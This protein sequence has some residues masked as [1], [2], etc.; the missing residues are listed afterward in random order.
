MPVI[1]TLR[2]ALL[3]KQNGVQ[4]RGEDEFSTNIAFQKKSRRMF[5]ENSDRTM[6]YQVPTLEIQKGKREEAVLPS[7]VLV[8]PQLYN[9]EC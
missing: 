7:S 5:E 1:G 4:K 3:R 6:D 9:A 8:S 2:Q